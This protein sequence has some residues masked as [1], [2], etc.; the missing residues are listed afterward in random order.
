MDAA[1]AEPGAG[2][3]LSTFALLG[4]LAA[5]LGLHGLAYVSLV[6]AKPL[7]P[8]VNTPVEM[9]IIQPK[10]KPKPPPPVVKPPEPPKPIEVPKAR[11]RVHLPPPPRHAPP[12]PQHVAPPPPNQ[13]PPP[14]AAPTPIN[15][16]L[17]L[18]S[19]TKSGGFAAPVGNSM[20][21]QAPERAAD[22][23]ASKPYA[24]PPAGPKFVP[25]YQLTEPPQVVSGGDMRGFYP[26]DARKQ[27]LEGQVVLQITIDA[28]GKVTRAKVVQ[29]AGHGFDQAA[30]KGALSKLRFKP[31]MLGGQPVGTEITYKVTFLLD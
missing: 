24:A 15:I 30:V 22:P 19:T 17:S 26:D 12:P 16:G 8:K 6:R 27:G 10:P 3:P 18:S 1:R 5:S 21:G 9:E 25:S 28:T 14:K 29:G 31:A 23:H 4:F 7:P 13:P 11:P 20:M 2:R